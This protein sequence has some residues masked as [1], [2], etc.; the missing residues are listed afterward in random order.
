MG[1][2]FFFLSFILGVGFSGFM[3]RKNHINGKRRKG[4]VKRRGHVK[5]RGRKSYDSGKRKKNY[6]KRKNYINRRIGK[7]YHK[8]SDTNIDKK[9]SNV[10]ADTVLLVV[11]IGVFL[12]FLYF[13]RKYCKWYNSSVQDEDAE[14]ILSRV[15]E[16]FDNDGGGTNVNAS[17]CNNHVLKV[18]G[19]NLLK[20][21]G[22]SSNLSEEDTILK[23]L[24][25][26]LSNEENKENPNF[27]TEDAI[28]LNSIFDIMETNVSKNDTAVSSLGSKIKSTLDD[29]NSENK[30][31]SNFNTV[32]YSNVLNIVTKVMSDNVSTSNHFNKNAT[33]LLVNIFDAIGGDN[34]SENKDI[35][36][37]NMMEC[38]SI[39]S[40]N[41]IET[42]GKNRDSSPD[43]NYDFMIKMFESFGA[44]AL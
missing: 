42:L 16:D 9:N 23:N 30:E 4:Y 32:E 22:Y 2:Y 11:V 12:A 33:N 5:R 14:S 10:E 20:K 18:A 28:E 1:S 43:K 35:S 37:S 44:K 6:H 3:G 17:I 29:F 13:Y 36:D 8:E 27:N 38:V 19:N 7:N 24:L 40:E 21:N 31:N 25:D 15:L 34:V 39:V 41:F 26:V